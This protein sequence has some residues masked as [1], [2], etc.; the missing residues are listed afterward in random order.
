[1]QALSGVIERSSTL[2]YSQFAQ[3]IPT[4]TYGI[5]IILIVLAVI[6]GVVLYI[7]N[8]PS[9]K[10]VKDTQLLRYRSLYDSLAQ[11]RRGVSDYLNQKDVQPSKDNWVLLNFAPLT[12]ADAGYLGPTDD[13]SYDPIAI[14]Q[15]LDLG[16][17]SFVFNIDFYTGSPKDPKDFVA[18]YEPCLLHRDNNGVIRSRN[19]GRIDVMFR[20]L[21]EQAF[22]QSIPTGNDPL[23]VTLDFKNVPDQIKDKGAYKLFLQKVS[24]AIQPLRKNFLARLGETR[25]SNL[26]NPN[27]LFTQ[28]FQSLQGKA[29]I[30]TNVN[31]DI[32]TEGGSSS[33]ENLRSM[34]NAQIYTTNGSSLSND[35][36]TTSAPK[37]TVAAV[38]RQVSSYFLNTPPDQIK[39]AQNKTN[40]VFTLINIPDT[41]RNL[42]D[43]ERDTLFKTYGAQSILFYLYEKPE[44]TEAFLKAW[45]PWSWKLKPKDLQYIVVRMQPPKAIS[46]AANANQ[47][48]VRTPTLQI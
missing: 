10:D 32:F 31:T 16:F 21:A 6:V 15:A 24:K 7:A 34:I 11:G 25:F 40:N 17:R 20:A 37:G 22:S 38:G 19:C 44:L 4:G 27:A 14:R 8:Q 43:T 13:G 9:N 47:G 33:E 29:L 3:T 18:P 28:N 35:S 5:F 1:M 45:G 26:E 2:F 42:P 41:Y 48:N 36:V 23:I 30:F 39:D 46:P 12:V